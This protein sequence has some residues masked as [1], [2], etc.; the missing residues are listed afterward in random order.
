MS[1]NVECGV[2]S[3]RATKIFVHAH[4]YL[5]AVGR[6]SEGDGSIEEGWGKVHD[7]C[8]KLRPA[9]RT[10]PPS[11][12]GHSKKSCR[13]R[14]RPVLD[15]CSQGMKVVTNQTV[16]VVEQVCACVE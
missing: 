1:V 11:L 9:A 14:C 2:Y 4:T 10:P 6:L 5:I 12:S 13:I 16:T 7:S 8:H 3:E 15:T